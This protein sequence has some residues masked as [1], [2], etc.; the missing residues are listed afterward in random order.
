MNPRIDRPHRPSDSTSTERCDLDPD[1]DPDPD[2]GQGVVV[3]DSVVAIDTLNEGVH[4]PKRGLDQAAPSAPDVGYKALA[5]NLSDLAAMGAEPVGAH[6]AVFFP[7]LPAPVDPRRSDIEALDTQAWERGFRQG[8]DALAKRCG[9]EEARI[10]F[11]RFIAC[12][13]TGKGSLVDAISITVN[14]HGRSPRGQALTRRGA[15]PGDR[16]FVSG[17]LG[18][19]GGGLGVA[20]SRG[21]FEPGSSA[22]ILLSRLHRPTPRLA[23]GR[24]L[25]GLATAAI[26]ISDGLGQDLGHLLEAG[27]VGARID[28]RCLPISGALKSVVGD[29]SARRLA[30]G[31]GDDYEL[32][33]TLPCESEI[34]RSMPRFSILKSSILK[35]S[36]PRSSMPKS[37]ASSSSAPDAH[38]ADIPVTEIG[39]IEARS[40]LRIIG[41]EEAI[42]APPSGYRHFRE[43][44]ERGSPLD[45]PYPIDKAF[46]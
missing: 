44:E 4:F 45:A 30:L 18:D 11:Q 31:A 2:D 9:I 39:R 37:S 36:M 43:S 28:V 33:F 5:V 19:A 15:R 32:L 24:A 22:S 34:D 46:S 3:F 14:V 41:A 21:A 12:E 16:I 38:I 7:L 35:S 10:E 8:F 29:E 42:L 20:S 6:A 17:T 40:G 13:S 1:L 23:L 26:D 27:Q 25:R